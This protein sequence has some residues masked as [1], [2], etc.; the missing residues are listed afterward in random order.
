MGHIFIFQ[1]YIFFIYPPHLPPAAPGGN[2][3]FKTWGNKY[4]EREKKG[5]VKRGGKERKKQT[6]EEL[7]QHLIIKGET[8]KVSPN[9][10]GT[11]LG[12]KISFW[13]RGAK[14]INLWENINP[15]Y[16]TCSK[17]FKLFI[18]KILF[19]DCLMLSDRSSEW[20]RNLDRRHLFN[21]RLIIRLL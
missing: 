1:E 7:R 16:L 20:P 6:W 21:F 12:E 4:D 9:L 10:Y 19:L 15:C 11:H 5:R 8:D 14:S 17:H 18:I 3:I 2:I 13:K